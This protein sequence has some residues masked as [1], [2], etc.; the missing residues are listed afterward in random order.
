MHRVS[1]SGGGTRWAG[2]GIGV[3]AHIP[4]HLRALAA[5]MG[6][7]N[8]GQSAG[9]PEKCPKDMLETV[10]VWALEISTDRLGSGDKEGAQA[11]LSLPSLR[12]FLCKL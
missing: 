7:P 1:W 8:Q 2:G 10:L 11:G 5:L 4:A 9:T 6:V 12:W 3:G